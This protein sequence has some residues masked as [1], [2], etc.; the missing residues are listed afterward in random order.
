M[1][2]IYLTGQKVSP[3]TTIIAIQLFKIQY[4]KREKRSFYP[5][6]TLSNGEEQVL[7]RHRRVKNL[8]VVLQHP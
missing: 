5:I 3:V 7:K 8:H 2:L 6:N 4:F 1:V